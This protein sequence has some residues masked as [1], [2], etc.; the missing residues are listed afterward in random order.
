MPT[1]NSTAARKTRLA[2]FV[3][4]LAGLDRVQSLGHQ[5]TPAPHEFYE[6][7]QGLTSL[8][9]AGLGTRGLRSTAGPAGKCPQCKEQTGFTQPTAPVPGRSLRVGRPV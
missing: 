1:R 3:Q 8:N 7:I 5:R 9:A 6:H 2:V 4:F